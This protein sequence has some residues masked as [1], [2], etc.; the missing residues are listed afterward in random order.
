[1]A[2]TPASEEIGV[3]GS[4]GP[5]ATPATAGQPA[6]DTPPG[7][8]QAR[9]SYLDYLPGIYQENE[10]SDFLGRFLLIFEH[11][12]SPIDRTIENIPYYFDPDVAPPEVVT[13]LG[14]WLGLALDARWPE[15]RRRDLV[16]A[17]PE[18]FRWRGTRQGLAH[19]LRLYTGAEP[20]ILEPSLRDIA[21]DRTR[22]FRFTVRLHVARGSGL[23]R[24]LVQSIIEAE[25]PAFAAC[26]LEWFEEG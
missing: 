15:E 26:N 1:M 2:M 10:L 3:N 25:K 23:S 12:L 8:P 20:E 16:K 9:S 17:A 11:I 5:P 4:D 14:S 21:N 22:A 18:L 7:I 13:W 24:Q 6:W 19:F